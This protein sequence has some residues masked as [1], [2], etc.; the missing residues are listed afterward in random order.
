MN[1]SLRPMGATDL[2]SIH[3]LQ[4]RIEE[5]DRL[6]IATPFEEFE[7][8]LDEP[9]F[10]LANDARVVEIGGRIAAWGRVWHQPSVVREVRA[11]LFGGVDPD[12][13]RKGVGTVLLSWQIER[14]TQVL[15]GNAAEL[16]RFVRTWGYDFQESA[17]RLY[18]RHGLEPV[19]YGAEMLRD[20]DTVSPAP[21]AAGI[22]IVPWDAERAEQARV[23]KNDAFADHWGS[24]PTD[25][26]AWEHELVGHGTRLDLSFLALDGDRVVGVCRNAFFPADEAVTGRRDG[27]IHQ[28][29]VVRSH[30]KRGIASALIG[31][32]L[33]AFKAAGM[34][35][36][37]LGVDTENPTGAYQLYE[38]LGYRPH[39][40]SVTRQR[41]V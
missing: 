24:T 30:R 19:R 10:E 22:E 16:P 21:V 37:V 33:L 18:A 1:L 14:A 17:Q 34:T 11:Y 15:R 41:P 12:E 38:R 4:R 39:H 40:R 29:S 31:R 8:W 7:Q 20:L 35:H 9:H 5:H 32:S 23:A 3:R 27:W 28:V 25:A 26:S 13:R 6:P 36:S 2:E